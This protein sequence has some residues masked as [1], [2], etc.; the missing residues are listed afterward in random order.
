MSYDWREW[1]ADNFAGI[2]GLDNPYA[3]SL[4]EAHGRCEPDVDATVDFM[5]GLAGIDPTVQLQAFQE[6]F[7]GIAKTGYGLVLHASSSASSAAEWRIQELA[8][9]AMTQAI[10]SRP[11]PLDSS[12]VLFSL[13]NDY[14]AQEQRLAWTCQSYGWPA[15]W[16]VTWLRSLA[17][18]EMSFGP[19]G[20]SERHFQTMRILKRLDQKSTVARTHQLL[21]GAEDYQSAEEVA[22]DLLAERSF[23]DPGGELLELGVAE[24]LAALSQ[25]YLPALSEFTA[26]TELQKGIPSA[27]AQALH[28]QLLASSEDANQLCWDRSAEAAQKIQEMLGMAAAAGL[29]LP[30][31]LGHLH[32]QLQAR[33]PKA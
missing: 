10:E 33:E 24:Q 3:D 1:I 18:K 31:L 7:M 9:I 23:D 5:P 20:P 12:K 22:E 14:R 16:M 21:F 15:D 26:F 28:R 2:P 17:L 13:L 8:E 30:A 6:E 25:T 32:Q 11:L 4:T 29:S 27:R 19:A